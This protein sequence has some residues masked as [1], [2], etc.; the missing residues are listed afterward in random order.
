MIMPAILAIE[1]PLTR[2]M[3]HTPE[4]WKFRMKMNDIGEPSVKRRAAYSSLYRSEFL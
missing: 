1:C 2:A 4:F 3:R